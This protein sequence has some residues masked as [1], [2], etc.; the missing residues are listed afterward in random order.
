MR[1]WQSS[2]L[3]LLWTII[4]ETL[5]M[6]CLLSMTRYSVL[7]SF[8]LSMLTDIHFLTSKHMIPTTALLRVDPAYGNR[9]TT[10]CHLYASPDSC[11]VSE[12]WRQL[13]VCRLEMSLDQRKILEELLWTEALVLMSI[14]STLP[15]VTVG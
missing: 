7:L 14:P 9:C 10:V 1:S 6:V 15:S 4:S 3:L 5:L 12:Q 11:H 13:A 8:S 2:L